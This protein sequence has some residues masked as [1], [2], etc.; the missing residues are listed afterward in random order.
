[1]TTPL[2]LS[3]LLSAAV[4][5]FTIELDN[6]FER[7]TPEHT[8]ATARARGE[9]RSGPWLVSHVM[10]VNVLRH[11]DPGGDTPLAEVHERAATTRDSLAGLQRW[12]YLTVSDDGANVRLTPHG[13]RAVAV[14]RPLAAEIEGRWRD[15]FGTGSV[16]R[17]RAALVDV[18]DGID[19]EL[20]CALPIV[21]PTTGG[22]SDE[23]AARRTPVDRSADVATLSAQTLQAF[24]V[25][26]ERGS[27]L[28]LPIGADVLRVLG[29]NPVRV[30]D[31]PRLTGVSKEAHAMALG[32][33]GRIE[34]VTV[35]PDPTG[36][37]GRV[38][39]LTP[40]GERAAAKHRR[41]LASTEQAWGATE[42][43]AALTAIVGDDLGAGGPLF[44]GLEPYPDGWRARVRRPA[45]LPHHPM[46][47]HRGGYPDGS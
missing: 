27:R 25:D 29:R 38:V 4:V 23:P 12:R 39:A 36:G 15:R 28:S 10:Y 18:L 21:N 33:L 44:A 41:V 1:M 7:R 5:A 47:L 6:E 43:H 42:L 45:T 26:H 40:K 13:R 2:G 19:L 30:A 31:L 11:V 3:A 32:F 16:T 46:V 34:C 9:R 37:R 20:P 17:L 22:R 8:T 24:T 35:G 14:W